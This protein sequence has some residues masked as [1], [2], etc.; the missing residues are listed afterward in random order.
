MRECLIHWKE[1][2]YPITK[3]KDHMSALNTYGIVWD[4][5]ARRCGDV[6]FWTP[7]A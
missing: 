1:Y 6:A 7:E 2:P 5:Q 4:L 3:W